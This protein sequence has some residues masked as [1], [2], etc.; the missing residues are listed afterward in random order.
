VVAIWAP[1]VVVAGVGVLA[2]VAYAI[3]RAGTAEMREVPVWT[4]GEEGEIEETRYPAGSFYLPFKHAFEKAYP[5]F[6]FRPP[7]FPAWLRRAFDTD[8]WLFGPVVRTVERAT[9]GVSKTHVG[10]PQ[11][12]LLWIVLGC[13]AVVGIMLG[14]MT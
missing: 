9:R 13:V 11:V 10:T 14:V 12:Y 5:R 4:C 1:L 7:R 2:L 8:G 3:Q 6:P